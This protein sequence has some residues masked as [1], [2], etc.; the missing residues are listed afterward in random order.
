MK[1]ILKLSVLLAFLL[2]GC[3]F[4]SLPGV[5]PLTEKAIGGS[6]RDKVLVIDI[7]GEISDGGTMETERKLWARIKEELDLASDDNSVKAIVLRIDSPGGSVTTSDII[8]HELKEFKKKKKIPVVA[9]LMDVAASGGYYVAVGADEIIAHPTTVTGSIG[10][11][12]YN[13]DASGLMTKVGVVSETIKSGK[14]KDMGSPF[15]PMT[16]EERKIFQSIIDSLYNRFLDVVVEG[17]KGKITME[18][19]KVLA[20]GRVFTAQQALSDGLVDSIGYMEDAVEAAKKMA[21]IK[22]A[23]VITYAP[24]KAYRNNLY[25]RFGSPGAAPGPQINLLNING[26]GV[27]PLP[28]MR[29]MYLWTP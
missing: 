7:S 26:S 3:V 17:R 4:I 25:S 11:I 18:R 29:F 10:V 19:L 12:A 21:G 28:R 2:T 14:N 1:N 16:P 9:S 23:T 27:S 15:K 20:D 13:F 22:E 24:A 8:S 5:R 6:G